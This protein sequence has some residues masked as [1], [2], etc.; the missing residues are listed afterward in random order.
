MHVAPQRFLN[1]DNSTIL[2]VDYQIPYGNL[3]F[4]AQKGG[5]FA[6]LDLQVEVVVGTALFTAKPI[7]TTSAF[8]TKTIPAPTKAIST[9]LLSA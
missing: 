2:N 9:G 8:R 3:W 7:A 1:K 5:Y 6:E 4:L